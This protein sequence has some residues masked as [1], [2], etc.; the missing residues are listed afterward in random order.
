EMIGA[1][2]WATVHTLAPAG[3][4]TFHS[5]SA[6]VAGKLA[7]LTHPAMRHLQRIGPLSLQDLDAVIE[8]GVAVPWRELHIGSRGGAQTLD[9]VDVLARCEPVLPALVHVGCDASAE[10]LRALVER[11]P[12]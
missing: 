3:I 7:F 9:L 4:S 8:H 1:P 12:W 10:E 6:S 2:A 5:T 11:A